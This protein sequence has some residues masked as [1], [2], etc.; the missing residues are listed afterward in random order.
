MT[1]TFEVIPAIDLIGGKCVR[2]SQGDFSRQTV[3]DASPVEMAKRFEDAGLKRLHLVDL[4]GAK[5]GHVV[6]LDVLE[7]V[8][9]ATSLEIDFSGGIKT[10]DELGAVFGVGAKFAGVGSLAVMKPDIFH[11]WLRVAGPEKILLGA[12]VRN[13]KIAVDGWLTDTY[14]DVVDFLKRCAEMGL[15][16]A[17]VTDISKD[18]LLAG[19]SFDL[20]KT[21]LKEVPTLR[22]IASG[23]VSSVADIELLKSIGCSGVIVGKAIYEG[24][25]SLEELSQ[26]NG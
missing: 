15:R 9:R 24:R 18:G 22:L 13:G 2:L 8:A 4:D 19:A 16:T 25:I 20:Y 14:L 23:G 21:I 3:Y 17:Y 11:R 6:N 26:R 5:A 10:D 7:S 1:D 12:D